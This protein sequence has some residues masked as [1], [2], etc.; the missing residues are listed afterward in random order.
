MK[1]KLIIALSGVFVLFFVIGI[2]LHSQQGLYFNDDFW[3][4]RKDGRFAGPDGAWVCSNGD[5]SYA[6]GIN[7]QEITAQYSEL[8]DGGV[9]MDYSD[10]W[11][12]E[13]PSGD[14]Y[15]YA[16]GEYGWSSDAKLI[17]TDADVQDFEFAAGVRTESYPFY[18]GNSGET[19]GETI[20]IMSADGN[21]L[22]YSEVWYGIP[23]R[24]STDKPVVIL[25]DGAVIPSG[26]CTFKSSEGEYLLNAEWLGRFRVGAQYSYSSI[27]RVSLSYFLLMLDQDAP[28]YR[29]NVGS[30]L[31]YILF[32]GMGAVQLIL[33]EDTAFFGARWRFKN[34]PE[35]SD[36]GRGAVMIGGAVMMVVG[37]IML[38]AGL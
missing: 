24:N 8:P 7:G 27:S 28:E 22:D 32:F 12:V 5:G 2:V 15:L 37:I 21:T 25:E 18:D 20:H 36:E 38:F 19:I 14:D 9:R 23:E 3:R 1:K 26:D 31:M 30:F 34:D 13:R 33:P 29:G 16:M 6:M 17:L 10:G 11:A 4:L 35:L